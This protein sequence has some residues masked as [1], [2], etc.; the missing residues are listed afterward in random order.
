M[1][2][3]KWAADAPKR[4]VTHRLCCTCRWTEC[5]AARVVPEMYRKA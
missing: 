2:G 3:K 1:K 5:V 4:P